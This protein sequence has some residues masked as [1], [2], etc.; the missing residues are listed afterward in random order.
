MSGA[1]DKQSPYA[2]VLVVRRVIRATPERLFDAWTDAAQLA[3]WW[4]P[5]GVVC[6]HASIDARPGG[7]YRIG[8]RLPDGATLWI[9]GEFELVDR[10][11][12][13]VF[14]WKVEGAN[15]TVERVAVAFARVEHGTEVIVTHERIAGE[16]TRQR[17]AAGWEGCLEGLS[18]YVDPR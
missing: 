16:I 8:N 10:P 1:R 3:N 12:R 14:S 18:R 17:H 9:T 13:L 4:G 7:S 6:T 5:E 15:T 11:A 2:A